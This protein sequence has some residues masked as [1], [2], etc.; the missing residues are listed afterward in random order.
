MELPSV[1]RSVG[2]SVS[3]T[4]L[5]LAAALIQHVNGRRE[6]PDFIWLR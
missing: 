5:R 2:A 6:A 3:V 4:S 1:R